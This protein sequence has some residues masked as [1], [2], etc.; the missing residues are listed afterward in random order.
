MRGSHGRRAYLLNRRPRSRPTARAAPRNM[1][2]AA[3]AAPQNEKK[4]NELGR[5][6]IWSKMQG[7]VFR[8]VFS[9]SRISTGAAAAQRQR[10]MADIDTGDMDVDAVRRHA[11]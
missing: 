10:V 1:A 8:A 2:A 5:T 3:A 9:S 11:V 4:K 6:M 7:L